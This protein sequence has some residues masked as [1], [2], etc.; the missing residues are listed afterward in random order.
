MKV[1][2]LVPLAMDAPRLTRTK[3]APP[4]QTLNG[5]CARNSPA[6]PSV[7]RFGDCVAAGVP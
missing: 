6:A 7:N 1:I 5:F 2:S 4:H 3:A